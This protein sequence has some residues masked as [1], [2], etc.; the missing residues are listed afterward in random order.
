MMTFTFQILVQN[1]ITS[2]SIMSVSNMELYQPQLLTLVSR[3]SSA[4]STNIYRDSK[5]Y[6]LMLSHRTLKQINPG[7]ERRVLPN[8]SLGEKINDSRH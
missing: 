2:F 7:R 4:M 6:K 3:P 1:V 5:N 8:T